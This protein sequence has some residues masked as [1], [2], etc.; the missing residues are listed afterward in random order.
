MMNRKQLLRKLQMPDFTIQGAALFL[1]SHPNDRR[2]MQHYQSTVKEREKIAKGC[3]RLCGPLA[4]RQNH[5]DNW[6][7]SRGPWL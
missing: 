5:S 4:N 3:E 2:A 7:Y 6:E 1:N